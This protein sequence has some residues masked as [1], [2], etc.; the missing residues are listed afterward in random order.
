MFLYLIDRYFTFSV[1]AQVLIQSFLIFDGRNNMLSAS[2][3]FEKGVKLFTID[4]FVLDAK[5][6]SAKKLWSLQCFESAEFLVCN[7]FP[8]VLVYCNYELFVDL[9]LL[10]S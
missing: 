9:R 6:S 10:F 4:Y 5:N 1:I 3:L 8:S 7:V 2:A